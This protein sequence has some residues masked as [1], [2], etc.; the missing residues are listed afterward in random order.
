MFFR[1]FPGRIGVSP[2][3]IF[4]VS[5]KQRLCCNNSKRGLG[6]R[7]LHDYGVAGNLFPIIAAF[8]Y[9]RYHFR[10]LKDILQVD[11]KPD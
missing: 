6:E 11:V 5:V 10:A 8:Y 3:T 7:T 2:L 1:N 4:Q 9:F